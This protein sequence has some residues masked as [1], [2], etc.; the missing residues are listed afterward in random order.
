[1]FKSIIFRFKTKFNDC[2][3]MPFFK[4]YFDDKDLDHLYGVNLKFIVETIK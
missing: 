2:L 4:Y 1:M 3:E